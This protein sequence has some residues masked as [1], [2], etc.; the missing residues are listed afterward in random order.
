MLLVLALAYGF[1][2]MTSGF[3]QVLLFRF[4]YVASLDLQNFLLYCLDQ[5]RLDANAT[6]TWKMDGKV[7][8][9]NYLPRWMLSPTIYPSS[10]LP[11][12]GKK[13]DI[14]HAWALER[15]STKIL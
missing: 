8:T 4:C 6:V 2:D 10:K 15:D 11:V 13:P 7:S 12:L 9:G 3:V 5:T 1:E 14:R